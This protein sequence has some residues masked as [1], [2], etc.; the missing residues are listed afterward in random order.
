MRKLISA[1]SVGAS[2]S[3]FDNRAKAGGFSKLKRV[4]KGEYEK[5]Y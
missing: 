4:G 5:K 1:P 2:K 3:S